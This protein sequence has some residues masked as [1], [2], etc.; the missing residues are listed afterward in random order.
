MATARAIFLQ[1]KDYQAVSIAHFLVDVLNSSR[2][3]LVAILAVSLGL[4]N[5]Q[6]AIAL[7]LYNIGNALT[8]LRPILCFAKPVCAML[9]STIPRQLL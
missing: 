1:H 8:L 6:V 2:S 9:G 7:L 5:T 4:S 3:L